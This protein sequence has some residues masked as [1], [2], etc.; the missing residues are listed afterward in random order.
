[1]MNQDNSRQR[2]ALLTGLNGAAGNRHSP[3]G[4]IEIPGTEGT[5]QVGRLVKKYIWLALILVVLGVAGGVISVALS[6]PVYKVRTMLEV[7]GINEA[8][9]R[10]SFEAAASFDSTQVN[11]QTQITLLK[12]GPF[13]Q[14]VYDRL[15][16]ET[17]PPPPAQADFFSRIRRRIRTDTQDPI[18]IM[19]D[20]LESA[21]QT[22]D[23]RPV[24]GTRLIEISCDSTNPQMASQ[25][26]NTMAGEFINE[27]MRSRSE[28]SQKTSEWLTSQ[29]EETKTKLQ[30]AEQR[31]QEFVLH[32][33]NMFASHDGTLDDSKLK[34]LQTELATIQADRIAKQARYQ[35]ATN[36]APENLPEILDDDVLRGYQ[37]QLADLLRQKAAL[38]TT[39]M[40]KNP[41]VAKIDAQVT[42]LRSD[43]QAEVTAVVGRIKNEYDS[44][45]SREKLLSAAYA[46]QLG[47]VSAAA[48]KSADY[49]ALQREVDTLRQLYQNLLSQAN[50]SGIS[51]SVPVN[52]IRLVQPT[53]PPGDPYKPR[54][55]LNLSFGFMSGLF[56]TCAIAFLRERSDR[57]LR[58]PRA[59]QRIFNAPQ[60]GVIPS[61]K[62]MGE[63]GFFKRLGRS[64]PQ[65]NGNGSA[66]ESNVAL[67][68]WSGGPSFMAESFRSTLASLMRDSAGGHAP[69]TILITSPAPGEGKTTVA[70][71]LAMALAESGRK[72][73]L[74]DA[75]FRRPCLHTV[76]G[77][78]NDKGLSDVLMED[79][80][81]TLET[82]RDVMLESGVPGVTV[83][84]NR[85]LGAGFS[86]AFYSP[87]LR[88]MFEEIQSAF[89]I[90]LV[91]A[92][93]FLHLADA[94]LLAPLTDG[95]ILVIRVG[96]TD[97]ESAAEAFECIQDDGLKLLG[98]V[99]NDWN[100]GSS[101]V[102][103]HY[104]YYDASSRGR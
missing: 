13:L 64:T 100:P 52:P 57:S 31:M 69:K 33:G 97:R 28:S 51:S 8:W 43:I 87:Y 92:P 88:K 2:P 41:K 46:S 45:Q 81:P 11:I 4:N 75:D 86:K 38:E 60:L 93:P 65:L 42:A 79:T 74:V 77:L 21:F 20:G 24:N 49:N 26:L 58:H 71:N 27:S 84:V 73:L 91:D 39:L 61:A 67:Q 29:I 12:S 96:I 66:K 101:H 82:L 103:R 15:Q 83:L 72:V 25:F 55:V 1:M 9:L 94:R 32:S 37:T 95:V 35:M 23:A 36:S 70:S 98:T 68:A 90:V 18:Q 3:V 102:K 62:A 99:L 30:E 34:Q 54:P 80:P 17:V 104:Y 50:Q 59:A 63:P 76:F 22:F 10:N 19:K 47:R 14:R 7:Q 89:D 78:R 53:S 48:G 5:A 56:L 6:T 44:A 40:P 16:A 85:P